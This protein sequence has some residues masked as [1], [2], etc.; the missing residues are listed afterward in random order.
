MSVYHWVVHDA[1]GAEIRSSEPFDSKEQAEAWMGQEWKSLLDAGGGSASLLH[2]GA[3]QYQMSL[4][5]E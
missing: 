1:T 3:V 4:E 5:A 2:D